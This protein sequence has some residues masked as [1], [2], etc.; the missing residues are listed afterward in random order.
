M[1]LIKS[2]CGFSLRKGSFLTASYTLILYTIVVMISALHFELVVQTPG[3]LI[4]TILM[5][6]MSGFCVVSSVLLIIGLCVVSIEQ[7]N[8]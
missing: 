4:I 6:I 7:F 5:I 3:L 8:Y 1:A 2:C